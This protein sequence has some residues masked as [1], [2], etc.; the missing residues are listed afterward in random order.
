ME[1]VGVK[2]LPEFRL[3]SGIDGLPAGST[4]EMP[5]APFRPQRSLFLLT[6]E[7]EDRRLILS[8]HPHVS[9]SGMH[10]DLRSAA[11]H[12]AANRFARFFNVALHR[13]CDGMI[14]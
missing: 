2:S 10:A 13:R 3:P 1:L 4:G 5:V 14:H 8:V 12:F 7:T 9:R 6:T 11:A